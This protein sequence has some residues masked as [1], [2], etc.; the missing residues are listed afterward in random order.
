LD[1]AA[2]DIELLG[3]DI[4]IERQ[5][6]P[7]VSGAGGDRLSQDQPRSESVGIAGERLVYR[8]ERNAGEQQAG[9]A[10][11]AGA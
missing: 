8:K 9:A 5:R 11:R 1:L 2:G 7:G 4:E 10:E 6:T 3:N